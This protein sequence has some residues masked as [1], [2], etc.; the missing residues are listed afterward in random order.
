MLI[1]FPKEIPAQKLFTRLNVLL[2]LN[3]FCKYIHTLEVAA[4]AAKSLM[5]FE[6][7]GKKIKDI[8]Q[9]AHTNANT[10][11]LCVLWYGHPPAF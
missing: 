8:V 6:C 1:C 3:V 2:F 11:L 9:P 10:A 4:K 7:I 5:T